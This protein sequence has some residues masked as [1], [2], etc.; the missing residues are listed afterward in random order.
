MRRGCALIPRSILLRIKS[1]KG[2]AGSVNFYEMRKTVTAWTFCSTRGDRSTVPD[3]AQSFTQPSTI[4][5]SQFQ[6]SPEI[7][8]T[9]PP[10][11]AGF[12]QTLHTLSDNTIL[13]NDAL[14][15]PQL[16]T[17]PVLLTLLRSS[18]ILRLAGVHQHGIT[19]LLSLTPKVTRL[20]HS[21]GA[22]L[23]VRSV[24]ASLE[25]QVA[26]LL[27]D[28]SHTV[29]SHVIDWALSKPGEESFH[30][31]HKMRYVNNTELPG[32]LRAGGVEE[33]VLDE[34]LFPLV[35]QPAPHLCA[36]RLDYSLRDA[37]GF[38]KLSVDEV[39]EIFKS[40]KV[41]PDVDSGKRLL[42][43]QD[44]ELALKLARAY[45]AID[46]DVWSNRANIDMYRRTG[47]LIGDIMKRGAVQDDELWILS[48]V[49]FWERL[50][51]EAGAEELAVMRRLETEGLPT[52]ENLRLPQ[53]AKVRTI[54]PDVY[55]Q[56]TEKPLPLS[57]VAPEWAAERKE[58]I[59][60]RQAQRE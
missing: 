19:G 48:D 47:K 40:L 12:F 9:P 35:E 8:P 3:Q 6:I 23:L 4:H 25:E 27:H 7:N 53:G 43:L 36:D 18:S 20:E 59:A 54:D 30:E 13:I 2:T 38:G 21:I 33:R 55:I 49:E 42:V 31:V 10:F 50:R 1:S 58:Y 60:S 52:E 29:L 56:G 5:S 46:R 14:Y 15:G 17:E 34:E 26:A 28:I 16:I 24:G 39:Q 22:F 32:L 45:C 57:I 44:K 41:F 11:Q 37:V 51:V